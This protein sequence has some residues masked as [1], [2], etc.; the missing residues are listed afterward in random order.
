MLPEL[1][2]SEIG[3]HSLVCLS[4]TWNKLSQTMKLL[5]L[6]SKIL[7]IITKL[8]EKD[9]ILILISRD[10]LRKQSLNCKLMMNLALKP[11]NLSARFQE[12]ISVE[13]IKDLILSLMNTERVIITLSFLPWSRNSTRKI[14]SKKTIPQLKK[15]L[16]LRKNKTKKVQRSRNNKSLL[17][18]KNKN[19]KLLK[20]VEKQNVSSSKSIRFHSLWSNLMVATTT[21][22]LI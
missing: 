3:E 13:F 14:L 7:M 16:R 22:L 8:Q 6:K 11:G 9:S 19:N 21:I 20:T 2:M 18:K 4:H 17:N 1:I 5:S 12:I 15:E 10:Y